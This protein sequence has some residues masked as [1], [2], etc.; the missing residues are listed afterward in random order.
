MPQKLKE[1][2]CRFRHCRKT[3]QPVTEWQKFCSVKHRSAET[4]RRDQ[5]LIRKADKI[6][7]QQEKGAA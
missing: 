7:E 1:K 2:K 6:I 3:F 5:A 4:Y